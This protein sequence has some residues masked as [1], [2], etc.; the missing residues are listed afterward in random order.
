[1]RV[2]A[3]TGTQKKQRESI[4]CM[5]KGTGDVEDAYTQDNENSLSVVLVAA[6]QSGRERD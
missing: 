2:R 5:D 1:M 4:N 6:P 3:H